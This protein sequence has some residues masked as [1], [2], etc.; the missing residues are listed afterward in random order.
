MEV[1]WR[2]LD[3]QR[4]I[5]VLFIEFYRPEYALMRCLVQGRADGVNYIVML[6]VNIFNLVCLLTQERHRSTAVGETHA[7][8]PIRS[9]STHHRFVVADQLHQPS[10]IEAPAINLTHPLKRRMNDNQSF[11]PVG[12]ESLAPTT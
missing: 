12:D 3:Q 6:V 1:Q 8:A 11:D 5:E 9:D 10:E 2:I 4:D 7:G